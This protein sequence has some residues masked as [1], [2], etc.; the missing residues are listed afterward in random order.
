[1]F[2]LPVLEAGSPRCRRQQ[3]R[4]LT[5][6]PFL[7]CRQRLPAASSHDLSLGHRQGDRALW[8]LLIWPLVLMTSFNPNTSSQAPSPNTVKLGLQHTNGGGSGDTIQSIA[9]HKTPSR[10]FLNPNQV[11]CGPLVAPLRRRNVI[12]KEREHSP[13]KPEHGLKTAF[14]ILFS[15]PCTLP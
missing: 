5:R 1:M 4:F 13:W 11:K 6:A 8:S 7:V 10:R 12:A 2:N 9:P 3:S 15:C 14:Y